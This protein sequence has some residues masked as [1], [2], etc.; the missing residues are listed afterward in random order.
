MRKLLSVMLISLCMGMWATAHPA[1]A[2]SYAG[3]ASHRCCPVPQDCCGHTEYV[4]QRQT[5]LRQVCETIYE[6]KQV[7]YERE[8]T[9]T[10]L[11]PRTVTTFK[12]VAEKHV[13][14]VPYTI[15]RPVYRTVMREQQYTVQRRVPRTIY[16]D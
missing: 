2:A 5:V 10:H 15:Q 4:L 13:R 14:D 12:T 16:K 3:G 1:E 11:Q 6:S 7:P 9:E 8:V